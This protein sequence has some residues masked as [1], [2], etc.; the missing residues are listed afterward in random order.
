MRAMTEIPANT[1]RPMGRT[2]SLVPGSSN[3]AGLLDALSA[4]ELAVLGESAALA[5]AVP[6]GAG[7]APAAPDATLSVA[8]TDEATV[9]KPW[10]KI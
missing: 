3:L 5:A 7:V 9:E 2:E 4:A 8:T 6:L 1:P 10:Q